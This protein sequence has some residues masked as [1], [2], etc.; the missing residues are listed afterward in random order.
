[1]CRAYGRGNKLTC[2]WNLR[3][4][5]ITCST[6]V[7]EN[8]LCTHKKLVRNTSCSPKVEINEANTFTM[9]KKTAKINGNRG[10]G[11]FLK[12]VRNQSRTNMEFRSS[13]DGNIRPPNHR[14]RIN[15]ESIPKRSDVSLIFEIDPSTIRKRFTITFQ[16]VVNELE[17]KKNFFF[18]CHS[19]VTD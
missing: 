1:M 6:D 14:L 19:V 16:R 17:I 2:W 8:I 12:S 9:K 7:A 11:A 10:F 13:F 3:I 18:F 15:T 5:I 4:A